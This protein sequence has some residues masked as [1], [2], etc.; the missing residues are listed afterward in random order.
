[1]A[2]AQEPGQVMLRL[3]W[4]LP[5]RLIASGLVLFVLVAG[6]RGLWAKEKPLKAHLAPPVFSVPGG[7]FTNEVA[8][9]LS[10]GSPSAVIGYT[11]DGSE[12]TETS[13]PYAAPLAITN[14]TVVCARVFVKGQA[15]GASGAQAYLLLDPEMAD[16][17]SNLP[18]LLLHSFGTEITKEEKTLVSAR[19]IDT[20]AGRASI[21]GEAE[22]D[23]RGVINLRGRASLRYPKHSYTLK[24]VDAE[25]NPLKVSLLGLPKESDWVLY[26]PY[27]DKTLMRDVLAYDL[28]NA[29]GRWAPRARFVEIFV[30]ENGGKISQR[31]YQGVYV[32]EEKVK[33]DKNRVNIEKL[34]PEDNAEPALSGGYIFKKD[35]SDHGDMGPMNFGGYP[36]FQAASSPSRPG[37]PTGPGGFP[38]DAAGFQPPYK[39]SSRGVSSSSSS[40]SRSRGSSQGLVVT[41]Y[42]GHPVHREPLNPNRTIFRS[43]DEDYFEVDEEQT[44]DSFRSSR[45]NKF[46]YVDPEPDEL[47]SV[48]RA[49]LQKCVNQCEA[50]LY[51][52][53]FKDPMKGYARYLDADSCIDYHLLVE[54][55]KNV[56]GFRFSAF[57]HKDRGG[58]LQMG[59]L[60]D[61]NLSFGNCNGKQGYLAEWWLWPQLDDKEYSWFRRLF[62]DP[63]FGQKYVDRWTE[64]RATAFASSNLLA[65]VDELAALLKEPQARNFQRWPILGMAVNPNWYVGDSYEEEVKWMKEW[66]A[67]RLA[68][69]DK[70][71]LSPPQITA[72]AK[73]TFALTAPQGKIFFSL[74][75]TDPRAPGGA[76]SAK[77]HLYEAPIR[78]E[79]GTV[80][81]ARVSHNNR[82]SGPARLQRFAPYQRLSK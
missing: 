35:H 64:L 46:Y 43:D 63:D 72:E 68:W 71:F 21:L 78:A 14:S 58:K 54:V 15:P 24:M 33:R 22:F 50:A 20:R 61:W 8:L 55:T 59:P 60:W 29:I 40:S 30:N 39:G 66:I 13:T 23:G 27:P 16:F 69:I 1:M 11:L 12:P 77:A 26:G 7:V 32:F 25:E 37:F 42:L 75:G 65:R 48:Q 70:Q 57:F 45:T 76:V 74:D 49:W 34:G 53:D 3:K 36:A 82:W 56:D 62:E 47:T 51:G 80:L 5:P 67:N 73:T 19:F 81:V 52:P 31:D 18:L 44:R 79:P 41:N 17:N 4:R 10:A 6:E 2:H 28:S 9:I 38:G